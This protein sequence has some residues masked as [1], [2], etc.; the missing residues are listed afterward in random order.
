MT[1]RYDDHGTWWEVCA[2]EPF[3]VVSMSTAHHSPRTRGAAHER[4]PGHRPADT[5]ERHRLCG[6]P[7]RIDRWLVVPSPSLRPVRPRGLLRPV[8]R[9]ARSP[10]P[11]GDRAPAHP[12]LRARG[13]LVLGLRD[14]RLLRGATPRGA[15]PS[16]RRPA[17]T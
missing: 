1:A 13:G 5:A 2:E 17:D 9:P 4:Q 14:W 12:E 10:P 8:T 7:R 16:P 15:A 11:P 3:V 6:V